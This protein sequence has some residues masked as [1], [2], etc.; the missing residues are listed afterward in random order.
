MTTT[1]VAISTVALI[2]FAWNRGKSI[3][4]RTGRD[5]YLHQ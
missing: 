3:Q 2:A 5:R 1:L 4:A